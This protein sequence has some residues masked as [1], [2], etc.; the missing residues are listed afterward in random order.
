VW[1]KSC[2]TNADLLE[3]AVQNPV[4]ACCRDR[5]FF[6]VWQPLGVPEPDLRNGDSSR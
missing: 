3:R 5:H 6:Q 2:R 4:E 1:V